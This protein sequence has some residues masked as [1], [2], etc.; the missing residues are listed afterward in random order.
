MLH[1]FRRDIQWACSLLTCIR[2]GLDQEL[3]CQKS[4]SS[5]HPDWKYKEYINTNMEDYNM[6]DYTDTNMESETE[7]SITEVRKSCPS[8]FNHYSL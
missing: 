6:E 4:K 3:I 1:H 8:I 2:E 7:Q 5:S